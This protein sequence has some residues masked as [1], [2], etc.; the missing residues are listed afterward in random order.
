MANPDVY[1]EDLDLSVLLSLYT[2]RRTDSDKYKHHHPEGILSK[3][4]SSSE[5]KLT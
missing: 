1:A 2:R 4:T 5:E 3:V